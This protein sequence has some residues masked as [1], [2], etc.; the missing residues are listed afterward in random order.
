MKTSKKTPKK[1]GRRVALSF[2]LLVVLGCLSPYLVVWGASAGRFTTLDDVEPHDVAIVFGAGLFGDQPSPYLRGRL[3]MA[4]D[5]YATGK[6]QVL[7]LTGDN[8]T[9]YHNEPEVM[10]TWLIEYGVP[11]DRI[12]TDHAGEDTYSSCVRATKIFGVDKAILVTQTYHMP[13]AIATCRLVGLDVVG[14]GDDTVREQNPVS[15]SRYRLREIPAIANML[16][17]VVSKREPIL[18]PYE[19]SVDTALGR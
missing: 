2:I 13:R 10:R 4:R 5:L 17:E 8:L 6:A 1:W 11:A 12:V 9:R 19:T 7:L 15:W 18:G 14:V 16:F 3:V